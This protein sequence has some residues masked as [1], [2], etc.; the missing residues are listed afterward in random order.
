MT[1]PASPGPVGTTCEL[2]QTWRHTVGSRSRA[3]ASNQ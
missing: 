2:A 3:P 1:N